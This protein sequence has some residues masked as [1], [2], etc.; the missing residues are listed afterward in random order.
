M[1]ES[2]L[3]DEERVAA[4]RF[5][6]PTTRNQHVVGRGMARRLLGGLQINEQAI[7][8]EQL[9]HGKPRVVTPPEAQQPFNVA[10]TEGLVLC[11]VADHEDDGRIALGV[12]V[13]RIERRTSPELAQRYFAEPEVDF[14][15]SFDSLADRQAMFLRIWTLKESF[16]KAIGTGLHTPLGDFAFEDIASESPRLRLLNP[17]LDQSM[18]WRFQCL[19]PLDGFVAAVAIGCLEPSVQPKILLRSFEQHVNPEHSPKGR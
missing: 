5:R 7:A 11:G 15:N 14:L 4:D 1:C 10:H 9:D 12:D 18:H 2:W 13:E 6:R 3:T 16:I 19:T 8:F 17:D